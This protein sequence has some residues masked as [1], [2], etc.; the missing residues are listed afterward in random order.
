MKNWHSQLARCLK[1]GISD[2]ALLTHLDEV[3]IWYGCLAAENDDFTSSLLDQYGEQN[4]RQRFEEFLDRLL[5][6][7]SKGSQLFPAGLTAATAKKR[8]RQ[9]IRAFHPDRGANSEEWL[10]YRAEK[11]NLAYE[12][13]RNRDLKVDIAPAYGNAPGY[14]QATTYGPAK[15]FGKAPRSSRPKSKNKI[16]TGSPRD[17]KIRFRPAVW[18]RRLGNPKTLQRNIVYSLACVSTFLVLFFYASTREPTDLLAKPVA[19]SHAAGSSSLNL[20]NDS[21]VS[22]IDTANSDNQTPPSEQLSVENQRLVNDAP[23]LDTEITTDDSLG[24]V[25][26]LPSELLVDKPEWSDADLNQQAIDGAD[27]LNQLAKPSVIAL[28][29]NVQ[30]GNTD[31]ISVLVN[32]APALKPVSNKVPYENAIIEKAPAEPAF[33]I[34]ASSSKASSEASSP[35]QVKS[36]IGALQPGE[37]EQWQKPTVSLAERLVAI[38][39][40]RDACSEPLNPQILPGVVSGRVNTRILKLRSGPAKECSQINHLV[41]DARIEV[42]RCDEEAF[43]CYVGVERHTD[44]EISGWVSNRFIEYDLSA[45]FAVTTILNN[46]K[47]SFEVGDVVGLTALFTTEA[48]ENEMHGIKK[49]RKDYKDFFKYTV[50]RKVEVEVTKVDQQDDFGAVIEGFMETQRTSIVDGKMHL[51]K[52]SFKLVVIKTVDAFKIASFDWELI[53]QSVSK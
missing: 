23:W 3:M 8:Y 36:A 45:D 2:D 13:H 39:S 1:L 35:T 40:P 53:G 34:K 6:A 9:L 30:R 22:H 21:D 41:K 5:I 52:S 47:N 50:N 7:N 48:R 49:I 28:A 18:R 43:W 32:S 10:N 38:T 46:Y 37:S 19:E 20:V 4:L 16:N 29:N 17:L 31:A 27:N 12:V 44:S 24:L 33:S 42:L 51:G 11:V 14:S 15:G 25:D 26:D